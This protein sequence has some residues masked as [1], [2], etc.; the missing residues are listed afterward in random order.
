M[1]EKHTNNLD[2]SVSS[3]TSVDPPQVGLTEEIPEFTPEQ[4]AWI[5]AESARYERGYKPTS[6]LIEGL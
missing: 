1:A 4:W 5:K 3:G 2:G 6:S